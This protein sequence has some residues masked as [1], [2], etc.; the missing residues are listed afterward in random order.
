MLCTP[1]VEKAWRSPSE[2]LADYISSINEADDSEHGATRFGVDTGVSQSVQRLAV[3][4]HDCETGCCNA[5]RLLLRCKANYWRCRFS[6]VLQFSCCCLRKLPPH[7][8]IDPHTQGLQLTP[9][10]ASCSEEAAGGWGREAESDA[11]EGVLWGLLLYVFCP[12]R[13]SVYVLTLQGARQVRGKQQGTV[14]A[15]SLE[16]VPTGIRRPCVVDSPWSFPAE[17]IRNSRSS[18]SASP[19]MPEMQQFQRQHLQKE[20]RM[21]GG[22]CARERC[23]MVPVRRRSA[24][25]IDPTGLQQ[26]AQE[27]MHLRQCSSRTLSDVD[28]CLC[29]FAPSR[30]ALHKELPAQQQQRKKLQHPLP[31]P[32]AEWPVA[33]GPEAQ[34]SLTV[35]FLLQKVQQQELVIQQQERQQQ[36]L[37]RQVALLQQR[38]RLEAH[39]LDTPQQQQPLKGPVDEPPPLEVAS[40]SDSRQQRRNQQDHASPRSVLT[41]NEALRSKSSGHPHSLPDASRVEYY[42]LDREDSIEEAP[43][44]GAS[45][46]ASFPRHP[47]CSI[48]DL[49]DEGAPLQLQ[50]LTGTSQEE[51]LQLTGRCGS[52]SNSSPVRAAGDS[53]SKDSSEGVSLSQDDGGDD[54][55]ESPGEYQDAQEGPASPEDTLKTAQA[56]TEPQAEP[57]TP[58]RR[59]SSARSPGRTGESPRASTFEVAQRYLKS[60]DRAAKAMEP[61]KTSPRH[62]EQQVES[63]LSGEQAVQESQH[64]AAGHIAIVD[65]A[66]EHFMRGQNDDKYRQQDVQEWQQQQKQSDLRGS[67]GGTPLRGGKGSGHLAASRTPCPP[68]PRLFPLIQLEAELEVGEQGAL[69]L[70]E[71]ATLVRVAVKSESVPPLPPLKAAM[72][73]ERERLQEQVKAALQHHHSKEAS[74]RRKLRGMLQQP[75]WLLERVL[76]LLPLVQSKQDKARTAAVTV[77]QLLLLWRFEEA[78]SQRYSSF[79]TLLQVLSEDAISALACRALKFSAQ[80]LIKKTE[81][82]R[83]LLS[84]LVN[85]LGAPEGKAVYRGLLFLSELIF[86]EEDGPAV[87]R[88]IGTYL[89][90]FRRFAEFGASLHSDVQQAVCPQRAAA[91]NSKREVALLPPLYLASCCNRLTSLVHSSP[92]VAAAALQ[93]LEGVLSQQ[94]QLRLLLSEREQDLQQT[95]ET[96]AD[97]P[98]DEEPLEATEEQAQKATRVA[99]TSEATASFCVYTP[100]KRDPRYTRAA[101]TRL[102]ELAACSAS[103]HPRIASAA[104]SLVAAYCSNKRSSNNNSSTSPGPAAIDEAAVVET[105]RGDQVVAAGQIQQ[106]AGRAAPAGRDAERGSDAEGSDEEDFEG[107]D[108]FSDEEV[109]AFLAKQAEQLGGGASE[110]EDEPESDRESSDGETD[111]A[112]GALGDEW[113]DAE[114]T[115]E[116][117]GGQTDEED[118]AEFMDTLSASGDDNGSSEEEENRSNRKK[119]KGRGDVDTKLSSLKKQLQRRAIPGSAFADAEGLEELLD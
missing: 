9:E 105:L 66:H 7:E 2:D 13:V 16:Y 86:R 6:C 92:G 118:E 102:W 14:Y 111:A 107:D 71:G 50:S 15:Y 106:K 117:E 114:E 53:A 73:Q 74:A 34:Q 91:A 76:A 46:G 18:S 88:L 54:A 56:G 67:A 77:L 35:Q 47:T 72:Q 31:L 83:Q 101:E 115:E 22:P 11:A 64:G 52:P 97:A 26:Q 29:G 12:S 37:Q 41:G 89:T 30:V 8:T 70:H 27:C 113:S 39:H 81:Q 23:Y 108:A 5:L 103:Y 49:G 25:N 80:L 110:D 51:W 119:R 1:E 62:Q 79:V 65:G 69:L 17:L 24:E 78:L 87:A 94:P 57:E 43:S 60:I 63:Q 10:R 40:P 116:M 75:Q 99:S 93:I 112:E 4:A 20:R 32:V 36:E 100:E 48:Y 38:A 59:L 104:A 109:D 28:I 3:F 55:E 44:R 21:S 95:D 82:E 42:Y 96:V 85:R 84:L 33:N 90:V 19:P 98:E 68:L 61:V 45:R 58:D